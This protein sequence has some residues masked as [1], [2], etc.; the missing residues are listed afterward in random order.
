MA[1]K[2]AFRFG[3]GGFLVLVLLALWAAMQFSP[4]R[5]EIAQI[6]FG[7]RVVIPDSV[8][9]NVPDTVVHEK[10]VK[11]EASGKIKG[12]SIYITWHA[13]DR[14]CKYHFSL[15][16]K[17]GRY[18]S[19]DEYTNQECHPRDLLNFLQSLQKTV[20]N[21]LGEKG[22]EI[23]KELEVWLQDIIFPPF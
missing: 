4:A 20:E 23:F 16:P 11:G 3:F 10:G 12:V 7:Q 22:V 6:Q 21:H 9:L 13:S 19:R 15:R 2:V 8:E 18:I 17:K 5:P 1:T 14:G